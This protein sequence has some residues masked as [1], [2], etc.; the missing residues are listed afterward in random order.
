[1]LRTGKLLQVDL[2]EALKKGTTI[3]PVI[4][5]NVAVNGELNAQGV[6]EAR[7]IERAKGRK[8]WG[9]DSRG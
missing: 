6:L 1:V 9:A 5:W 4:G 7:I 3:M 8:S 2:R